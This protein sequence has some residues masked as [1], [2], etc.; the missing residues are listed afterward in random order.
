MLRARPVKATVTCEDV[1]QSLV[2]LLTP[3]IPRQRE[4]ARQAARRLAGRGEIVV[5]QAGKVVP[6]PSFAKG[7]MELRLP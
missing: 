2:D 4:R 6:D 7:V 3:P 5:T 1:E